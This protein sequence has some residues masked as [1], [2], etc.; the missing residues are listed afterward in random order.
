MI[1][2]PGSGLVGFATSKKIGSKPQRNRAKRRAR[3]AARKT[4]LD[5]RLDYVVVVQAE[6]PTASFE[7]LAEDLAKA[8]EGM[9]DRWASE[10]ESS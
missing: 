3:E 2:Q 6:A 10:L 9:R 7:R 8:I 1:A 5:P 4:N